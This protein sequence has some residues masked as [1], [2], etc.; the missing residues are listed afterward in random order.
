MI[1]AWWR[2]L[3]TGDDGP[4]HLEAHRRQLTDYLDR[5]EQDAEAAGAEALASVA[6]LQERS[7]AAAERADGLERAVLYYLRKQAWDEALPLATA[8]VDARRA[9]R[10]FEPELLALALGALGTVQFGLEQADAA[11]ATF[12]AHLDTWRQALAERPLDL[13]LKLEQAAEFVLEPWGR[14]RWAIEVLR[15]S[16]A[17]RKAT[18]RQRSQTRGRFAATLQ[19]LAIFEIQAHDFDAGDRHLSQAARLLRG[20]ASRDAGN[21]QLRAGLVQILVLQASLCARRAAWDRS[22]SLLRR[23]EALR[24]A[25][26][27]LAAEMRCLVLDGRSSLCELR[28]DLAG[29]VTAVE[30]V[31][32]IRF[33]TPAMVRAGTSDEWLVTDTMQRLGELMLAVDELPLARAWLER[34]RQMAGDSDRLLL[35]LSALERR[36]GNGE[37]AESLFRDGL[38]LRKERAAETHLLFATDR[39]AI[40][41][42]PSSAGP[43][44]GTRPAGRMTLGEAHVLVPGGAYSDTSWLQQPVAPPLAVGRATNPASLHIRRIATREPDQFAAAVQ[45]VTAGGIYANATLVFVHGFNVTFEEAL[46]RGAQ[47]SRDL[48]FDGSVVVFSWPSQGAIRRYAADRQQADRSVSSLVDLLVRLVAGRPDPR[49]HVIAHSMG[50]RVLLQ[51]VRVLLQ[52]DASLAIRLGE[53]IMAAPAV[54]VS[55]CAV[56]LDDIAAS[57][58]SADVRLTLYAAQND[59]A[60]WAGRWA[61]RGVLAGYCAGGRPFRHAI[62]DSID[63]TAAA[64]ADRFGLRHDVFTANPVMTDDMRQLLQYGRAKAPDVRVPVLRPVRDEQGCFWRYTAS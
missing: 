55:E 63:I 33:E 61:D 62:V 51:A 14:R 28:G 57:A 6:A 4:P 35:S 38:R 47:L 52:R 25:D 16:V 39:S 1:G 30:E 2:G 15:E 11:D 21:E 54:P 8:V 32:Q 34:T 45:R 3:W 64:G 50:N 18:N 24:F 22:E 7:A 59:K 19:L 41:G 12:T 60:M 17:L 10:P 44:F 23:A 31:L 43:R 58:V 53:L 37:L 26:P 29:A 49:V 46:Q 5:L 48:N 27:A 56:W 36:H 13:A 20:E 42:G 40:E 9:A